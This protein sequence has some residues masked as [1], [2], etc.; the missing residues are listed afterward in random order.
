MVQPINTCVLGVGLSGLTFHVPFILALPEIFNLHSVLERNPKAE[1]GKVK[2]RF[3]V[4]P[5]IHRTLDAVLG[6]QE[7]ELVII[8]TP[9]D[10]HYDFANAVL[11]AGKHVLVDKPVTATSQQAKTL[12][13]LAK[14][15]GLVLYA[16]QN[17]RWDSDF[18][19]L[20]GLLS[21]P[22]RSPNSLG[23]ITEFESHYDRF[24]KGLKGTWKDEPLPAAGITYDLGSHLIDQALYLFGRP[25]RLTAFIQNLRGVG[26]PKVD[27]C[28]TIHFHY[29]AGTRSAYPLAVILRSH[30]LS[31]RAP[32]LRYVVR[33][34]KGTYTKYGLDVQE[35]QLKV[36]STPKGIFENQFGAE[37][38]NIWG[39]VEKVEAD[40][41]TVSK[42]CWPSRDPGAYVELF[43]NLG[44]AIREGAELAVKWEEATAV[45]EMVELAHKSSQEGMT[46]AVLMSLVD[47]RVDL[48]SYSRS[49]VVQ[50]PPSSSVLQVKQE[51]QEACPGQPRP[52]GQRLIW[53][54]RTPRRPS[55][56]MVICPASDTAASPPVPAPTPPPTPTPTYNIPRI[57][58]VASAFPRSTITPRM[59][60][61]LAPQRPIMAYVLYKHQ[62]ALST[63]SSA[64]QP[65]VEPDNLSLCRMIAH[66]TLEKNGWAWPDILD[67][68]FPAPLEGGLQ[69]ESAFVDGKPYL[70]LVE[71]FGSQPT[72]VQE[73]ALK[74]LTYTFSILNM[75]FPTS[76]PM[77]TVHAQSVPV[78][79]HVNQLLQQLGLP[80]MRPANANINPAAN[81]NNPILP[82]IREIPIRPLLAPF[83]MLIFRTTLLLYFVAPARKP[84]FGVLILAWMLYEIW[85]PIRNALLR[86]ALN[87]LPEHQRQANNGAE[88]RPVQA[89]QAQE[90]HI[91][92]AVGARPAAGVPARPPLAGGTLDQQAA[93][94][95]DNLANLNIADEEMILN[96]P[97]GTPAPEPGLG[98]KIMTF[99]S[100]LIT[101][102]HPA[103]WNRRRVALRRR[104]G[105]VRTEANMR[106]S[107][108]PPTDNDEDSIPGQEV[109]NRAAEIRQELQSQYS[110]RPRWIQQY[111]Q[112][113]VEEDWVDDSD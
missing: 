108:P 56:G 91:P 1:G 10:T 14:T 43:R 102:L 38:E 61:T 104:E 5:K 88:A 46:I 34:T 65:P 59:E 25:T 111:M 69:Y 52:E 77:R 85:Q 12:G 105:T 54:D 110:R 84:I 20:K 94:L 58:Y 90:P 93:V 57:P 28:F 81:P 40:D 50:V 49:F 66:Q 6:D 106:N 53:R 23:T 63:L 30:I 79:P 70:R 75:T 55:L 41:I 42:L 15:K 39:F 27:D 83:M 26:N 80:Q 98:H 107:A 11:N 13:D 95:F 67:E 47:I 21:E 48:P 86:N 60:F 71:D 3:G 112:R 87:R 37:P 31:V 113:V 68:D 7:I 22:E 73:R 2:E 64:V 89:N 35:D 17:R 76:P 74:V 51:I 100:L 99:M 97:A 8:G 18:L 109:N 16:F 82:E 36:I 32:Q 62:K 33:G 96:A 92:G 45:I 24:R 103:I 29:D 101:T 78:P 72:P 9:N 44:A 19:A 4:A